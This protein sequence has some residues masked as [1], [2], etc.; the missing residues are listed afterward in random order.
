MAAFQ[1]VRF[2]LDFIRLKDL[3][4]AHRVPLFEIILGVWFFFCHKLLFT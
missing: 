2:N 3:T 4:P 1:E